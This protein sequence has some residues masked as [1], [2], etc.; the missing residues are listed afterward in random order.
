MDYKKLRYRTILTSI[1]Q[2]APHDVSICLNFSS[3]LVCLQHT[4]HSKE[5]EGW[6]L[7]WLRTSICKYTL[8]GKDWNNHRSCYKNIRKIEQNSLRNKSR[9]LS[10]TFLIKRCKKTLSIL[11]N[12]PWFAPTQIKRCCCQ[13][14]CKGE[15]KNEFHLWTNISFVFVPR[16]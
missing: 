12:V 9:P 16:N 1:I 15:M 2:Q 10:H 6:Y 5:K 14:R 7:I 3:I 8:L 11:E 13:M 4:L